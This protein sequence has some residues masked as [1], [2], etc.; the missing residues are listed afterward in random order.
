MQPCKPL[1]ICLGSN[2]RLD[3]KTLQAHWRQLP[4]LPAVLPGVRPTFPSLLRTSPGG[5]PSAPVPPSVQAAT[6]SASG[7][8][9]RAH[10]QRL[11]LSALSLDMQND[12]QD[13][14]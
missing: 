10:R 14:R 3:S 6:N 11:L 5:S 8:V 12:G 4:H 2:L 9:F 7:L 1:I 13:F